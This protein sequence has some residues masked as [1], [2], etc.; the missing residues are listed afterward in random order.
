MSFTLQTYTHFVYLQNIFPT[1]I[2][3]MSK[4]NDKILILNAI[5]EHYKFKS[6]TEF[7]SFLGVTP[8]ILSNWYSRNSFDYDLVY[9]KCVGIN[10]NFL[11]GGK[12]EMFEVYSNVAAETKAEYG[13]PKQTNREKDLEYTIDVQRELIEVLKRKIENLDASNARVADVG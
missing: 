11:L 3:I 6:K 4:K 8:Q 9:T 2:H 10:G 5:K 7:A 13:K 1:I 12:G